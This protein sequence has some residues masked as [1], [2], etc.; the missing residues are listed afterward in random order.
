MPR[1]PLLSRLSQTI[2]TTN[3]RSITRANGSAEEGNAS[4]SFGIS[5]APLQIQG[6]LSLRWF[7]RSLKQQN[8][9]FCSSAS[10]YLRHGSKSVTLMLHMHMFSAPAVLVTFSELTSVFLQVQWKFPPYVSAL[11]T[12]SWH[13]SSSSALPHLTWRHQC[14][15]RFEPSFRVPGG[16]VPKHK[17]PR[18]CSF[19]AH[20]TQ[21]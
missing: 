7:C 16:Q 12:N 14:E 15:N 2:I 10:S 21:Q 11:R 20:I 4:A 13:L 1:K 8:P 18:L 3:T 5:W 19:Y 9:W 6:F 17:H